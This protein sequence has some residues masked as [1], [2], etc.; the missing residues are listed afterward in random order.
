M[1]EFDENEFRKK[2][3][4]DLTKKHKQ[5]EELDQNDLDES[6][7][8]HFELTPAAKKYLRIIEEERLFSKHK[9]FLKCVNHLNEIAWLTTLEI[10]EQHEYY[11]VEESKWD[12]FVRK[13][14]PVKKIKIPQNDEVISYKNE[15]IAVVEEDIKSRIQKY[16][17]LITH[18]E[19]KNQHNRIDEIIEQEE[20]SFY[21]SHPDYNLYQNYAGKTKWLTDAEFELEDDF[22]E[23]VKTKQEKI[24]S[25]VIRTVLFLVVVSSIYFI[26]DK[27]INVSD[28]GYAYITVNES[29]GQLY[30]DEV[31]LLGFSNNQIIPLSMGEHK[32]TYRKMG[33]LTTPAFHEIDV[34]T[35]DTVKVD[36]MLSSQSDYSKGLIVIKSAYEEAKLFV[37]GEFFGTAANNKEIYL[38]PGNYSIELKKE[39]YLT[40]PVVSNFILNEGDTVDLNYK[41][42]QRSNGVRKSAS[43][44][45]S[46]LLEVSSNVKGAKIFLNS[47]DTG[48]KTNYI[49]NN[50]SAGRYIVSL[51]MDGYNLYPQEKSIQLNKN[52]K[53]SRVDFKLTRS[54]M[55]VKI[56]TRPVDGI[57][58][59]DD[60]E[61]GTGRWTGSLPIGS[62][63][64]KFG[65]IK[66]FK[67]PEEKSFVVDEK[68]NNEFIFQ[69]Q[70]DFLITFSP[71]GIRPDNVG[72]GIQ[73]GYVD[74][75]GKFISDPRNGPSTRKVDELQ[76]N[77]WWLANAFNFRTP[78]ANEAVAISFY[79]PEKSEFGY[80][81]QMK[82]WGYRSEQRYPLEITASSNIR[83]KVNNIVIQGNF[84][85]E[86]ALNEAGERAFERFQLGNVLHP[87][88]NIII[89]STAP[90]NK[91]FYAIWK[92]A[93]E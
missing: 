5:K 56:I 69:Y 20:E 88:K 77:V 70:S 60:K 2:I 89:I 75:T 81:F 43:N 49:F 13:I 63:K 72:S 58:Y 9:Q 40:S 62:H 80:D 11:P 27:F 34:S 36:F 39:N 4:S 64:I 16:E 41:F 22:T 30:V 84:S 44:I 68:S 38:K 19:P 55:P 1:N 23:R 83:I 26:Y 24:R 51:Q 46:S 45:K 10:A 91:T 85:P 37:N 59:I 82:L 14:F 8:S 79:L 12:H 31:L 3:R 17:E 15:I 87:G 52:D 48:E 54:T 47:R 25:S 53:L 61:V 74:E 7:K 50:L 28:N 71:G 35:G 21:N 67:I 6:K 76:D 33:F 32:I 57:I 65:G 73:L 92:I 42:S 66:S 93:V 29:Q 78:P 86:Y 18:H 90:T